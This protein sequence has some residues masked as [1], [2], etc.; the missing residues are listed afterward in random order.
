MSTLRN[1]YTFLVLCFHHAMN[2][3]VPVTKS[4]FSKSMGS[5]DDAI[6][7]HKYMSMI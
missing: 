7:K 6:S 5:R 2:V 1:E 3:H 4:G